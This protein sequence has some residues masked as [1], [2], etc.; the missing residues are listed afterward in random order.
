LTVWRFGF[1]TLCP[2]PSID[3][4]VGKSVSACLTPAKAGGVPTRADFIVDAQDQAGVFLWVNFLNVKKI[5][6]YEELTPDR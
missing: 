2:A 3:D 4:E 1:S 5:N 6:V